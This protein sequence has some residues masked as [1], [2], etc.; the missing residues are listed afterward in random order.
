[1]TY[2]NLSSKQLQSMLWWSQPDT[3]NYD[4]IVCDGSVRSG[5]TMSMTVGFVLWSMKNFNNQSF[6]F[7][8]KTIDSLKRN[9]I[10]PMQKWLEGVVKAKV[11]LSSNFLDISLCG[12]TNRYY[13]FGGKDESSYQLIQGIT[14]AGILL[15]EVALM[16][17]SFVEQALARCSVTGSKLWFNCNPDSSEHWFFKEWIDEN[18]EKTINKNRLHLH[19]TMDD[20]FSLSDEIKQRYERMYSGVFYDRYIRGLWVLAEGLVYG[21]AFRK[22]HHIVENYTPTGYEFYYISCDYGTLNPCSMGLWAVEKDKAVRIKEYYYDGRQRGVQKTDEEYYSALEK[23]ADGYQIQHV[24]VDPSAASFITTIKRHGKFRV[25]KADNS[26]IDGIRNTMTLLE[27]DRIFICECCK[28]IIREFSLYR[29]DE[30]SIKDA[31]IKENDH[32][33]DDMR[34]FVNTTMKRILKEIHGKGGRE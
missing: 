21:T 29:W 11:N 6:A 12:H 2:E 20:N 22:E 27:N 9:V 17:K 4:A 8:G 33:M 14:L 30:K 32:A 25:R 15:D 3:K 24:I 16:P 5:K 31:V 34:Y 13:F 19:F 7:C 18:S 26:V 28:D 10:T 23:L 1:M